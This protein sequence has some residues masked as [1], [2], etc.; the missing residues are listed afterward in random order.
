MT[1]SQQPGQQSGQNQADASAASASSDFGNEALAKLIELE[2]SLGRMSERN[3][4]ELPG[5]LQSELMESS[6][7]RA[8]GDYARLIRRYFQEI[9]RARNP[10]LEESSQENREE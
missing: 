3:W 1:A 6:S 4:G 2:A 9:S 8:D 7:R 5:E 10:L